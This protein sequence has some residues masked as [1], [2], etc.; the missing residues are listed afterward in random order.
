[1][2]TRTLIM[3]SS[4]IEIATGIALVADRDLVARVLLGARTLR[5]RHRCWPGGRLRAAFSGT[6]W[7]ARWRHRYSANHTGVFHLQPDSAEASAATCYGWRALFM[8][9]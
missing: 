4:A 7:L 1:M 8:P 2:K 6:G 5:Q 9:C 3:L